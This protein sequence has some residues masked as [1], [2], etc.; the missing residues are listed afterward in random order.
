MNKVIPLAIQTN[1]AYAVIMLSES[2]MVVGDVLA[3]LMRVAKFAKTTEAKFNVFYAPRSM[4]YLAQHAANLMRMNILMVKEGVLNVLIY[5]LHAHH[6][7]IQAQ[8]HAKY[9]R[10]AS[11]WMTMNNVLVVLMDV[12]SAPHMVVNIAIVVM[13]QMDLFRLLILNVVIQ[14]IINFRI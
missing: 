14:T 10:R 13:L 4:A 5:F 11:S 12:L 2:Q 7:I 6:V 9:A 1:E 8:L 3:A